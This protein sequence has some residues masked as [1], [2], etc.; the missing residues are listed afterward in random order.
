MAAFFVNL[1]FN[2]T[3]SNAE[4]QSN[5]LLRYVTPQYYGILKT[6]LLSE[7][8]RLKKEHISTAF[9]QNNIE[10]DP[11]N[12]IARITGDIQSSVGDMTLPLQHVSYEVHFI[13]S[14]GRLLV[15]SFEEVK[16][17]A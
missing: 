17:H 11:K 13:Y 3:P 10:V 15:N 6:D 1:R 9:Y 12:Y 16:T 14:A 4:N 8:D 7:S 5:M 2:L